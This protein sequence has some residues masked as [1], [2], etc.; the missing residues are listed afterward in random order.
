MS[1]HKATIRWVRSGDE[2]LKGRFSRAH[3]WAFDGGAT[4]SASSSPSAVPVPFSVPA[5][6]DPEEAFVA[7][8]SS[9]HML[10]YLWAA[11]R[12]GFVVDSYDD[13]AVGVM[14]KNEK[15]IIWVSTIVLHPKI[16]YSGDKIP[17]EQD[18]ARFHHLAHENCFIAN[19][20]K[21]DI[22]VE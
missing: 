5:N 13:E 21:T 12:A 16:S 4:V 11:Y 6:V 1:E 22:R 3:T 14:T 17:T 20:V 10:T 2:F 18:I 9:C 19:S 8:V 7:S 15:G